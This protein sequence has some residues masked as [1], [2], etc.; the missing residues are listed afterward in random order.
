MAD[1]KTLQGNLANLFATIWWQCS[2]ALRAK[3]EGLK[4]YEDKRNENHVEWLM[5]EITAIRNSFEEKQNVFVGGY[6]GLVG[7]LTIKQ[8][9]GESLLDFKRRIEEMGKTLGHQN[10]EVFAGKVFE[11]YVIKHQSLEPW[12]PFFSSA[13]TWTSTPMCY[14]YLRTCH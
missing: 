8:E 1:K 9:T 6:D 3:L 4:D 10:I 5:E 12:R 11:D 7:M 13:S 14:K 2:D